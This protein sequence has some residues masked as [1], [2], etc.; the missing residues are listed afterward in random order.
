MASKTK[1]GR[2]K[3]GKPTK[4]RQIM[5]RTTDATADELERIAVELDRSVSWLLND[6]ATKFIL[7]RK[8]SSEVKPDAK[9]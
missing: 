5:M 7:R 3:S 1:R 2:P 8:A 4:D 9:P 6:I